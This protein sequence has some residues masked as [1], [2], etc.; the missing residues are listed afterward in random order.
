MA[1]NRQPANAPETDT[2]CYFCKRPFTTERRRAVLWSLSIDLRTSQFICS[3]C[4]QIQRRTNVNRSS[5]RI[6]NN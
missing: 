2:V 6:K 1:E 3:D 5:G 4:W